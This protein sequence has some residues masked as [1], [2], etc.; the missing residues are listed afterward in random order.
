MLPRLADPDVYERSAERIRKRQRRSADPP[1]LYETGP[2]LLGMEGSVPA[3][4]RR[5]ARHVS[6]QH[7]AFGPVT[8]RSARVGGKDRILYACSPLD[9]IVLGALATTLSE[10]IEP[11]LRDCLYS[12][13]PR[14]SAR[15]ALLAVRA[16]LRA[17]SQVRPDPRTRGLYVLRRDIQSYGDAL[18]VGADS[19]LWSLL[20]KALEQAGIV[21]DARVM[22]W[23]RGAFRPPVQRDGLIL[24]PFQ[25]GVPTGSPLQ[26]LACNLYLTPLDDICANV[27]DAFY[28]RYGDDIL[29]AHPNLDWARACRT[30]IDRC[31]AELGLISNPHKSVDQYFTR[32]GRLGPDPSFKSASH[33]EYLGVR[34]DFRGAFGLK[35]DKLHDL[36]DDVR[37]R[38]SRSA[39]LLQGAEPALRELTLSAVAQVALDPRH[40]LAHASAS[41][42]GEQVDDRGQLRDLDYKLARLLAG[43]LSGDASLRALRAYPPRRLRELGLPSLVHRRDQSVGRRG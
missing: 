7:Y 8:P 43:S 39:A 1:R 19:A 35:R 26:P 23:L 4:A 21:A 34:V 14:R 31:L 24:P 28:A 30:R 6:T 9:Q 16:Y 20:A 32:P 42:L 38:L 5:L 41:A 33:L 11:S 29:F 40:P 18:P 10:L 15:Q 12:Y 37:A 3:L 17:H 27:P 13:R 22:A 25:H 2:S 36:L